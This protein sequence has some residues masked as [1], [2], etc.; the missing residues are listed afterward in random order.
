MK[1]TLRATDL[2]K[3]DARFNY[4]TKILNS[5][6]GFHPCRLCGENILNERKN[7]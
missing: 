3:G 4:A 1:C 5:T 6:A 7:M 2:G